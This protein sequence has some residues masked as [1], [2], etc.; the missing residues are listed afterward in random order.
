MVGGSVEATGRGDVVE[1][2][3]IWALCVS[4]GRWVDDEEKRALAARGRAKGS[5]GGGGGRK[6]DLGG[7]PGGECVMMER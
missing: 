5:R 3:A 2:G 6:R 7:V 4:A 1:G